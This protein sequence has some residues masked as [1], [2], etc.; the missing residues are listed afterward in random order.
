VAVYRKSILCAL[1]Q[2][3]SIFSKRFL[4]KTFF[5]KSKNYIVIFAKLTN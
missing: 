3:I 5:K 4:Q 1:L 2:K